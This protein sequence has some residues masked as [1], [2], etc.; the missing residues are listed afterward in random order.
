MGGKNE[1]GVFQEEGP[2]RLENLEGGAGRVEMRWGRQAEVRSL[3]A[4]STQ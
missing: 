4:L 1:L 2:V 3:R